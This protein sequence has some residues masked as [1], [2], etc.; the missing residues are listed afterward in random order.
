MKKFIQLLVCF[1]LVFTIVE[2]GFAGWWPFGGGSNKHK[3]S[4]PVTKTVLPNNDSGGVVS[5]NNTTPNGQPTSVPEPGTII[6]VGIGLL[7]L[8][9]YGRR[10]FIK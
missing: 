7:G 4:K 8:A 3:H 1:L 9:G 6:L 2:S 5:I 10:K